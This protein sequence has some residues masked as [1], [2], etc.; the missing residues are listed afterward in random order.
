M[1]TAERKLE[2]I[3]ARITEGRT[4]YLQ[5]Y[6]RITKIEAKHLDSVR[7]RGESLEALHGKR[8]WLNHDYSRL[9]A[10]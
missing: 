6:T 7:V 8:G 9:S 10:R 2:W 1:N 5:T 4:V 3:K